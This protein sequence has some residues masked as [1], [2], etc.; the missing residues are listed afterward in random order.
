MARV[1]AILRALAKAFQR[2]ERSLL[3]LAGNNF[4]VV[5]VLLL[6]NAGGFLLLLGGLVLLFPLSTDP[7]RKVPVS[8]L[9]LWPL[10]RRQRTLLRALSPWVN[11]V[12]WLLAALAI[13]AARG[14]ITAGL[15]GAVAGL[16]AVAFLVSDLPRKPGNGLRLLVPGFPG[17]W[18]QLVRKNLRQM[19]TALD[20]YCALLLSLSAAAWRI[21]GQPLPAEAFLALTLLI[22]IAISSY[23]QSL[24]GFD[25]RSGLARY[26]LMPL[27]GWQILCAKDMA[28]LLLA[29]P[30]SLPLSPLAGTAA[31]LAALAM[32]HE[33]SVERPR[34]HHR[35]R[36]STGGSILFGLFQAGL[37]AM[38]ASGV[39]LTSRLVLIPCVAGWAGSLWYHGRRFE[40]AY[41]ASPNT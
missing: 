29:V 41:S 8:R 25:R 5:T 26:R 13:W 16:A 20:L 1:F 19:L 2:D 14:K 39:M 11:P 9:G 10:D 34:E 27:R 36:F 32:G 3:E 30:L 7:L 38:A 17:P 31:A 24:F 22:E 33:P 21:F 23:A 37:M 28:F 12:S 35:W 4:F 15:W 18:N 6:Q 40:A